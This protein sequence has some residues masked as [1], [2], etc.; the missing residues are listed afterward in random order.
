MRASSGLALLLMLPSLAA[1]Q[2]IACAGGGNLVAE[3]WRAEASTIAG[4]TATRY[5]VDLRH[6]GGSGVHN[7]LINVRRPHTLMITT[8]TRPAGGQLRPGGA[9]TIELAGFV[10]RR[11]GGPHPTP[12]P[13][14][15]Q[16]LTTFNCVPPR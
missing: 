1:A 12:A 10:R 4:G 6:G 5:F 16:S 7:W 8:D 15:I 3:N 2:S 9:V 13:S 11:D 14:T